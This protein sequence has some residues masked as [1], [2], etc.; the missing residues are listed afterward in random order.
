MSSQKRLVPQSMHYV[1][2]SANKYI[3]ADR[4]YT[5]R[6]FSLLCVKPS[7]YAERYVLDKLK[8]IML[9]VYYQK[10]S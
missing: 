4:F 2:K 5:P 9:L 1:I 7:G 10:I 6:R 3:N 8:L